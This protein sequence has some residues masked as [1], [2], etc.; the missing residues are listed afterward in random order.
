MKYQAI[1]PI[2][3]EKRFLGRFKNILIALLTTFAILNCNSDNSEWLYKIDGK[4]LTVNKLESAYEGYFFLMSMQLQ[5]TP[6][7]L[8]ELL[9]NPEKAPSAQVRAIVDQLQVELRKE[10]FAER[11]KQLLLLNYEAR[12]TGFL[13]DPKLEQRLAFLKQYFVA[14]MFTAEKLKLKNIDVSEQDAVNQCEAMRKRNRQLRAAP[15]DQCIEFAKS[16]LKMELAQKKHGE[17]I[18]SITESYKISSNPDYGIKDYLKESSGAQTEEKKEE[19]PEGT[20]A[21]KEEKK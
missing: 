1:G 15:I 4:K 17:F 12:K 13:S 8:K 6:E 18:K 21:P 14:N 19:K 7:Q 11:Y 5:A 16:R 2:L 9:K 10:S 3:I 20:D